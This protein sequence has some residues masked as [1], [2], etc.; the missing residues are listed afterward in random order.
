MYDLLWTAYNVVR[1][2]N[3]ILNTEGVDI[4][5]PSH[6]WRKMAHYVAS[7]NN[8]FIE[9][10]PA[11]GKALEWNLNFDKEDDALIWRKL[12]YEANKA[13]SDILANLQREHR[14]LVRQF[15]DADRWAN[16]SL[17]NIER[18]ARHVND[19]CDEDDSD[20]PDDSQLPQGNTGQANS[21]CGVRYDQF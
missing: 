11:H 5:R 10:V 17:D 12:N 8:L 15:E 4:P 1:H 3:H 9:W 2:V 20:A 7:I 14:G 19:I 16:W 6:I 21:R 18:G 13:C